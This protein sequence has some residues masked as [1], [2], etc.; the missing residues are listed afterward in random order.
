MVDKAGEMAGL[1][2]MTVHNLI[3]LEIN[4]RLTWLELDQGKPLVS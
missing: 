1:A 2:D 4:H 3:R